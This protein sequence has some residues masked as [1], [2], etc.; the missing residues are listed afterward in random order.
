MTD[1]DKVYIAIDLKSFY[2]SVECVERGLDPLT[3]KLVVADESRTEKTI[4]LAVTPAL[5]AYGL[6]GRCRLFEVEQKCRE[7]ERSTGEKLE[8]IAAI[9]RME[10]YIEVSADIYSIYLKY[11][12]KDD[13]HVYSIDEVFI[14][15]T[16]YMNLYGM[17]AYDLT[18]MVIQDVL[19]STGITATAGIAPNL[20]L[21]KIAMDI[22]AKHIKPDKDG[23]RIAQLDV[24]EYRRL[25]W[26]HKPLTDFW[27]IGPGTA[28][29]LTRYGMYTMG[30]VARVSLTDED[31][32]FKLFGVDAELI[33]DHAW[34]YEPCTLADIK[35]YKPK[36]NSLNSGQVLS[37]PYDYEK[38][39]IIVKEM[40]DL[41]V[42]DL[43]DKGLLTDSVTLS[44]GYDR[45]NVD[46]GKYT[47]DIHIDHYGRAVPQSANK[48]VTLNT[49]TSSSKVITQAVMDLFDEIMD[50]SLSSRR[51]NISFN[52][53]VDEAYMQYDF[54]S[55]P[56]ELERERKMQKAVLSLKKK[57]G[58]NA[59][60]KGMNLQEGATT[61]ERNSQIG[62]HR[63]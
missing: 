27:R 19:D 61:I 40:T 3:A 23:V 26:E 8:Y 6:S 53:V 5:K 47:G 39:R 59:V 24:E 9:P 28:G 38:T 48:S 7:V 13:I 33:I 18:R 34:G 58:K 31:W 36:V 44:I 25:L 16:Q 45:E 1:V 29:K 22:V 50:K 51:V 43:V 15:A 63:K 60:L 46:E 11:F 32:L 17:S 52:N 37:C 42:L 54:F 41:L 10:H 57:F 12:S 2:A 4:C 35:A 14:D 30:D 56:V 62:G 49:P 20:Y 55:D 21:C